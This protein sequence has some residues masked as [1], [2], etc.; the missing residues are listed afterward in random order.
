MLNKLEALKVF[1]VAAETLQFKETAN[2]LAIS[3]PVVTRIIAELEDHLAEPLFQRNTRQ[4][5]LTEFG[6]QFLPQAKQLLDETERLFAPTR[7]RHNQDMSGL[8]RITL[9]ELPDQEHILQE[10]LAAIAPYPD[11]M[12]DWH[13]S[14]IRM[15]A[16][17]AQ[18]DLGIRIGNFSDGRMITRKVG[19]VTEKIVAAP[20]LLTKYGIPTDV[21]DLQRNF[22]LS[23]IFD[24]NTGRVWSWYL[25][26]QIQFTPNRPQFIGSEGNITL[27]AALAGRVVAH[28]LD[29]LVDPYLATGDLV[30]LFAEIPK[31][32]WPVYVYRP[33]RAVTPTRVK[34]IFDLLVDIV[35][36]RF[37]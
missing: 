35:G 29:W 19:E 3:P 26:E 15:N 20:S 17:Q 5:K 13:K 27:Q 8:V 10:L 1:C 12:L 7:R 33:Q 6:Q 4:I 16:I 14:E 21:L 9:P 34:V 36:R 25:N 11:L 37:K 30:E 18:I 24:G 32:H 23:A 2:R 22:P 31:Y 28:Q